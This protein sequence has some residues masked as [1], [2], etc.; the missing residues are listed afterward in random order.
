M[1]WEIVRIFHYN[2]S[3]I[4]KTTDVIRCIL[5]Q[6]LFIIV[7]FILNTDSIYS[8]HS[9]HIPFEHFPDNKTRTTLKKSRLWIW[10]SEKCIC[11]KLKWKTTTTTTKQQQTMVLSG[12]DPVMV[13]GRTLHIVYLRLT[14]CKI[15]AEIT[16]SLC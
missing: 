1:F 3:P 8:T 6:Q 15:V 4:I 9:W 13:G 14:S 11:F 5:Q 16:W 12:F 10:V 7:Y 2:Y